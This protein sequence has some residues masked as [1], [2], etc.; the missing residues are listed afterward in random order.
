MSRIRPPLWAALTVIILLMSFLGAAHGDAKAPRAMVTAVQLNVR[1]GPDA[2]YWILGT[3]NGMDEMDVLGRN[4]DWSWWQ[5]DSPFGIGWVNAKWTWVKG[6]A[7]QVPLVETPADARIEIPRALVTTDYLNVREGPG[8][9]YRVMGWVRGWLTEMNIVG[10][11]EDWSWWQVESP[12]GLGWINASPDF[13]AVLGYAYEVPFVE[14]SPDARLVVPV[15]IVAT[16]EMHIRSGPGAD[17]AILGKV[18][19]WT[20]RMDVVGRNRDWSWWQVV[21]PHGTGWVR[22]KYVLIEGSAYHIPLVEPGSALNG[23]LPAAVSI[24]EMSSSR[25]LQ[26]EE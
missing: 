1:E 5:V 10:R 6:D 8:V 20:T 12:H 22:D 13:A 24:G 4:K 14:T 17:Y 21:S 18:P 9:K 2:K 25:V 7:S 3:V 16:P 19:G 26:S 23:A 15:A 11:N